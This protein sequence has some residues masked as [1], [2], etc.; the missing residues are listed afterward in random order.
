MLLDADVVDGC[1]GVECVWD[2]RG[3]EGARW[4]YR[5]PGGEGEELAWMS[6]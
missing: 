1:F 3:G 2:S 4:R 6:R 5:R